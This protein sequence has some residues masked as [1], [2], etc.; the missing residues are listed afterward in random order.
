[1]KTIG[2]CLNVA[3][4]VQL[5]LA[6]FYGVARA[7]AFD[8]TQVSGTMCMTADQAERAIEAGAG[9]GES[10]QR[11][12]VSGQQVQVANGASS[13]ACASVPERQSLAANSGSV[14]APFLASIESVQA[15]IAQGQP[16]STLNVGV[17]GTEVHVYFYG[18]EYVIVS[19]SRVSTTQGTLGC[20]NESS[21]RVTRSSGEI[22]QFDGCV[23]PHRR[24]L[25]TFSQLPPN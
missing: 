22:L 8:P 6:V 13:Q 9:N 25:P 10:R 19:F 12:L 16:G 14:P 3:V 18:S 23:E 11:L 5:L 20:A 7:A 21:Y 2:K 24:V 1:M 17:A 15:F 4:F